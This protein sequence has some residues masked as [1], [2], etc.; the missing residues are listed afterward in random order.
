MFIFN[1]TYVKPIMD[2]EKFLQA[3]ICY[4]EEQYSA[5]KFICSG[6]KIPRTGGIILCNCATKQEAEQIMEQ[7]PFFKEK[8]AKYEIIE[9]VPSKSLKGFE[10]FM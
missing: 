3:H 6:R 1:L 7:D 10:T 4:L 2:V 9:F 8:I 5:K